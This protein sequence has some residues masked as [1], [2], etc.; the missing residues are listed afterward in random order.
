M[1]REF[2]RHRGG[3]APVEM[4]KLAAVIAFLSVIAANW[5]SSATMGDLGTAAETVRA[6]RERANGIVARGGMPAAREPVDP[7]VTGSVGRLVERTRIDPC[8]ADDT[9]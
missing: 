3:S 2:L 7:I 6:D 5:I 1:L 4:A 8:R 9:R